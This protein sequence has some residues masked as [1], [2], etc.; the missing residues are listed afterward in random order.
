MSAAKRVKQLV[1]VGL[2]VAL[3]VVGAFIRLGPWSIAFDATA[4]FL[5]ALLLGGSAGAAVC[6]LGHLA[7][8]AATGFPLSPPLHLMI[9]LTMAVVGAAGGAAAARFGRPTGAAVMVLA[10]GIGAPALLSLMPNPLGRGLF[11]ATVAPLT[12]GATANAAIALMVAAA[13]V[14]IGVAL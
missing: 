2:L 4:G 11:L 1:L 9:A 3:S 7:A 12:A 10:N 5:A 13:L 8:A 6:A 14:R